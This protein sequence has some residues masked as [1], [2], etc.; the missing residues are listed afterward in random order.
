[1]N[2]CFKLFKLFFVQV[3][4]RCTTAAC[5][6]R[7][8]PPSARWT[9]TCWSTQGSDPSRARSAVRPSPPTATCTATAAPTASATHARAT[10]PA[11]PLPPPLLRSY[12]AASGQGSARQR[13]RRRYPCHRRQQRSCSISLKPQWRRQRR[14]C[15]LRQCTV[16]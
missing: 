4:P 2:I 10:V 15:R 13:R 8:C 6:G 14:Q 1:M 16:V 11:V 9:A 3:K 7:C 12:R 5:A